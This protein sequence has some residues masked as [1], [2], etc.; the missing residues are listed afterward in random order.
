[1]HTGLLEIITIIIQN[2]LVDFTGNKKNKTHTIRYFTSVFAH[3]CSYSIEVK[4]FFNCSQWR[5]SRKRLQLEFWCEGMLKQL[6]PE[7]G[8]LLLLQQFTV[9]LNGFTPPEISTTLT[10]LCLVFTII[11]LLS[12]L[13]AHMQYFK[14]TL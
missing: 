12:I 2:F 4:P 1:M 3:I 13:Y 10:T 5:G 7:Q 9:R 11:F 8:A 14:H 6:M